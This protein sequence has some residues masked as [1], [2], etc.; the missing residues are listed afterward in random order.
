MTATFAPVKSVK[1]E[2]EYPRFKIPL[3]ASI[4]GTHYDIIDW[5][6][7]GLGLS[8][9][10]EKF[11]IDK[12]Y[13]VVLTVNCSGKSATITTTAKVIWTDKSKGRAG[14]QIL[15]PPENLLLLQELADLSLS[16]KLK[17]LNS[18]LF[19]LDP[20]MSVNKPAS[21]ANAH[22]S[23]V[24]N[25][26]SNWA[27]RFLGLAVFAV[28]GL[29]ALFFLSR[30]FYDRFFTF[31]ASSAN[32]ASDVISIVAPG[33]GT[34]NFAAIG[35][36]VAANSKIASITTTSTTAVP[37]ATIS[38]PAPCDCYVL[39]KNQ[40]DGSFVRTGQILFTLVSTTAK[41]YVSIRIPFRHLAEIN[42]GAKISLT[43][44]DGITVKNAKVLAI[45]KII[46]NTATQVTVLVDPGRK[47]ST[48]LTGQPVY[49]VFDVAPWN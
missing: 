2:R 6:L 10:T 40:S 45:P 44:L 9:A 17:V 24:T 46:E 12:H 42:N 36:Q 13:L 37:T 1:R 16:G 27:K 14:M 47:M 23:D 4:F 20:N 26:A 5:S 18:S 43:Y 39:L 15:D 19:V 35:D 38:I 31:D 21:V 3:T 22:L 25:V 41:P 30:V 48:S 11:E 49:A 29:V 33:E 28:I 32:I 34:V 8:G 7:N